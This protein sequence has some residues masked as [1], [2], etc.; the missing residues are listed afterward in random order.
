[1]KKSD[2]KGVI[3]FD[4]IRVVKYKDQ[5]N[6]Y[7]ISTF[8]HVDTEETGRNNRHEEGFS[9]PTVIL[10][11]N[12]V[13][14][15]IDLSDQMIAYYSPARKSVKWLR[16]VLMECI[17]MAVVNSWVLCNRYYHGN[18]RRKMPLKSFV[19]TVAMSLLKIEDQALVAHIGRQISHR[20]QLSTIPRRADGKTTRKRC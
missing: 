11:Y 18:N 14:G 8:H 10:D 5:R 20:H 4:G 3:N 16:K 17:N 2:T 1:M 12:Q 6:V 9:K 13:K 19:K 15:V 7:M